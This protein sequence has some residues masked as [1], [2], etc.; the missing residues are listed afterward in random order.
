[1]FSWRCSRLARA[2]IIAEICWDWSGTACEDFSLCANCLVDRDWRGD[3]DLSLEFWELR[4]VDRDS[5]SI[6]RGGREWQDDGSL[7][8]GE[9]A[10]HFV[11]PNYPDGDFDPG[12]DVDRLAGDLKRIPGSD[13]PLDPGLLV[14]G[15]VLG[16]AFGARDEVWRRGDIYLPDAA[17]QNIYLRGVASSRE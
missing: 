1:M 2:E 3:P 16:H 12:L 7:S 14:G 5:D 13:S 4:V 9:G 17:V 10:A 11:F 15:S 8:D 6:L